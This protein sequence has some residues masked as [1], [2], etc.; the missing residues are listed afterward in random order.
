VSTAFTKGKYAI[1]SFAIEPEHL[2]QIDEIAR[3]QTGGRAAVLRQAVTLF[4]AEN[5]RMNTSNS[6]ATTVV[7]DV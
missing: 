1:V 4:L 3:Q 2:K 7:D 5:N 6:V